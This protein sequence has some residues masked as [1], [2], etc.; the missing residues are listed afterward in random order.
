MLL[1]AK[2]RNREDER[3]GEAY[4]PARSLSLRILQARDHPGS[5]RSLRSVGLGSLK[6]GIPKTTRILP[7]YKREATKER[8]L[9]PPLVSVI[10]IFPGE[11]AALLARIQLDVQALLVILPVALGSPRPIPRV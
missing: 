2:S 6:H 4:G 3:R 9:I 7:C 1:W 11:L 5:Q 8:T 10:P